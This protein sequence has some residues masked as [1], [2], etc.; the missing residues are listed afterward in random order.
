MRYVFVIFLAIITTSISSQEVALVLSGGGAKGLAHIGVIKALEENEIPIDY[1][2]GTSIG[3]IVGA[4]YAAGY[5][6]DE[7]IELIKSDQFRFWSTG[8]IEE[9]YLYYFKQHDPDA[10]WLELKFQVEDSTIKPIVPT[11]IVPNHQMDLA[12]FELFSKASAAANY[13][14][15]NLMIP[16]RCVATDVYENKAY[17]LKKGQLSSAVRASM[18]YPFYFKPIKIDNRLLFDG[19]MKNNFPVDVAIRD[20]SPDFIIGSKVASNSKPP[21][22]DD[23]YSQLENMLLGKTDYEIPDSLGVLIEPEIFDVGLM[24]FQYVDRLVE[25]GYRATI[26][27]IAEIKGKVSERQ[28]VE[29]LKAKREDFISKMPTYEF[30]EINIS[31]LNSTQKKYAINNVRLKKQIFSFS[32]F[33]KTYFRLIQDD[34]IKTI[35]PTSIYNDSTGYYDLFL[36]VR[37][38]N[39]F[40]ANFGGNISS[41]SLNQAFLGIQYKH[42]SRQAFNLSANSYY[43]RFYGSLQLKGR[44][45]FPPAKLAFNKAISPFYLELGITYNRWDF[46]KS[47]NQL[48]F[49]DVRPS[50]LIQRDNV[51]RSDIGFPL[52]PNSKLSFGAALA[53]NWDEYY[54]VENFLKTDTA[55]VTTFEFN[56]FHL[57]YEKNT[58]NYKQF[59]NEGKF[60]SISV[61]YVDGE[62]LYEPGSTSNYRSDAEPI[63]DHRYFR[64]SF[65]H[66]IFKNVNKFYT[67]GLNAEAIYTSRYLFYNYTST[68]LN[69]PAYQPVPHSKTQ[70]LDNYRAYTFAAVGMRN[71]FHINRFFD[72]RLEGFVFQPYEE[73][74]SRQQVP[75][76]EESFKKRY[77]LA[78]AGLVYHTLVGPV[79]LTVN[80]YD[81][82]EEKFYILFNFGYT[83]FNKRAVE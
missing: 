54:Q 19:G 25:S 69:S 65:M 4:M 62:E 5:T 11:S 40:E 1:I 83:I 47:S 70:F 29:E 63:R 46:F 6:T 20:F 66:D 10:S 71:I 67:I 26:N 37:R 77:I 14:F 2:A 24:D 18:T 49:E 13:D 68:I 81:K 23:L 12:F 16:F 51:I 36:R 79:S 3:A 38:D 78:S 56:T 58:L 74:V 50:Y 35:Y 44:I 15:D 52:T 57:T 34:I 72:F 28:T 80:Y 60:V 31:G 76:F 22:E 73:V 55:D 42:L 7:M 39:K 33:K 8:E 41:T 21:D 61:R 32:Q 27:R 17:E 45:D 48:F 43:G 82:S 75:Y 59:A 53:E 30:D 64:V 9:K